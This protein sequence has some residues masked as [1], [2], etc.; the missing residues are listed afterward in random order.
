MTALF[1]MWLPASMQIKVV[2]DLEHWRVMK[3]VCVNLMLRLARAAQV[4][5]PC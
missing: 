2:T 3:C 4:P 5:G 1:L